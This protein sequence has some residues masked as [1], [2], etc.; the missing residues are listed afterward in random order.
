MHRRR[1]VLALLAASTTITTTTALP[2]DLFTPR[3]SNSSPENYTCPKDLLACPSKLPAPF[4]CPADTKCQGLAADTTA[5]CCPSGSDCDRI[6]PIACDVR[7]QDP[8]EHPTAVIFTTV[9]SFDLPV[10]ANGCCP[11]GYSCDNGECL[12]SADQS[13]SP[14]EL[15][16]ASKSATSSSASATSTAP[17]T[18]AKATTTTTSTSPASSS[19]MATDA[20]TSST[21]V[22]QS[23]TAT[24]EAG[25]GQGGGGMTSKTTSIIGGAVGGTVVLV[26]AAVIGILCVR[27]RRRRKQ[28]MRDDASSSSREKSGTSAPSHDAGSVRAR[29]FLISEPIIERDN[30]RTDFILKSPSAASSISQRPINNRWEGDR[31]SGG[32]GGGAAAVSA[33][34]NL[35]HPP[36][37][38]PQPED[39]YRLS[40]P[41]PFASPDPGR[42]GLTS[43]GSC[44]DYDGRHYEEEEEGDERY[45]KTGEVGRPVAPSLNNLRD[46][47][48]VVSR[49]VEPQDM[50]GY[51]Y[52]DEKEEGRRPDS[53]VFSD[54]YAVVA[55][56]RGQQQQQQQ[57]QQQKQAGGRDTMFSGLMDDAGLGAI[58]RGEKKYVPVPD[59]TPRL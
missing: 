25:Q 44:Y 4:C 17:N 47:R 19:A 26:V 55:P 48:R 35:T 24:S 21:Q 33:P 46:S 8:A 34:R 57:K 6:K 51:G 59:R 15:A 42:N 5:L 31:S 52:Y 11:F 36:R 13:K 28:G 7:M 1:A 38:D 27:R 16:D 45:A 37:L 39:Q 30:F 12:R 50:H 10:C 54:E 41:N 14:A 20:H 2:Q 58:H 32:G 3:A 40:I 29:G 18:S 53:D 9:F 49:N 43:P 23:A 56:L 22:A